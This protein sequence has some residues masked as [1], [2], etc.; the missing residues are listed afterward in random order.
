[1]A[2]YLLLLILFHLT[3]LQFAK[4]ILNIIKAPNKVDL[5]F[6]FHFL[7]KSTFHLMKLIILK[8]T[9]KMINLNIT[10]KHKTQAH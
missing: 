1:M 5:P 6:I 3:F 7:F 10:P 2:L 9:I 4:T 8:A